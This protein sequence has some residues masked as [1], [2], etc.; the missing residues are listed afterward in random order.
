LNTCRVLRS[1]T[2]PRAAAKG[3]YAMESG[4]LHLVVEPPPLLWAADEKNGTE[5]DSPDYRCAD[6][7]CSLNPKHDSPGHRCVDASC[8]RLCILALHAAP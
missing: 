1:L 6:A 4:R 7:G 3:V 2:V 5:H 8:S